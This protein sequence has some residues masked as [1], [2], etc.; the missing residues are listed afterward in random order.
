MIMQLLEP[1]LQLVSLKGV[2]KI[3]ISSR[4]SEGF[5]KKRHKLIGR[6]PLDS[7]PIYTQQNKKKKIGIIGTGIAAS[8]VAYAAAQNGADVEMFESAECIA[9]GASGN[10][11]AAMYPRFSVNNSPYSFLTAQ[12]YFFAEKLYSQMPNAYKKLGFCLYTQMI[13][14]KNGFKTSK[15]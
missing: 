15:T 13:I 6:K 12:S 9:A 5:G 3:W 4:Q 14:K 8:S 2:K 7:T 1:L 10:P 11:V